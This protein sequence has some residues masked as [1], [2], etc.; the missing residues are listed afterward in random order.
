[1]GG[2]CRQTLCLMMVTS[3]QLCPS[4]CL[5]PSMEWLGQFGSL[6][7]WRGCPLDHKAALLCF[8]WRPSWASRH[9]QSQTSAHSADTER[10]TPGC[11]TVWVDRLGWP[12]HLCS[13]SHTCQ[14]TC[15]KTVMD[16]LSNGKLSLS[17][18]SP[19]EHISL[20]NPQHLPSTSLGPEL[21]PWRLCISCP[22]RTQWEP[23]L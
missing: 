17:Q 7:L 20:G 23:P 22:L 8:R 6:W 1:M 16:L 18:K 14:R 19:G 9:A 5:C 3:G 12:Q 2:T 13:T 11:R 4:D 10:L 15:D 21:S